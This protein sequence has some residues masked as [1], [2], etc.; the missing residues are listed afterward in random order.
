VQITSRPK[1]T[2]PRWKPTSVDWKLDEGVPRSPVRPISIFEIAKGA[3]SKT[4]STLESFGD[5]YPSSF[6][7]CF[8]NGKTFFDEG[9]FPESTYYFQK[10][11]FILQ[12]HL[13]EKYVWPITNIA[14]SEK[15]EF[16]HE[17]VRLGETSLYLA[18]AFING[19]HPEDS[20]EFLLDAAYFFSNIE[21]PL[22]EKVSGILMNFARFAQDIWKNDTHLKP[23][24]E[25]AEILEARIPRTF[26]PELFRQKNRPPLPYQPGF[27]K[28]WVAAQYKKLNLS[29]GMETQANLSI[30]LFN[31]QL[32]EFSKE[33]TVKCMG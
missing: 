28:L 29:K 7:K 25:Y 30:D 31:K 12:K 4:R 22:Y 1:S 26:S 23:L 3:S 19:A 9:N 21:E 15:S 14:P 16:H 13:E 5:T 8:N 33:V 10:G 17:V 6:L 18:N 24:I 11:L 2:L 32:A 27:M 20:P